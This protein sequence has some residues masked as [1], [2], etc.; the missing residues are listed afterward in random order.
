MSSF[1]T[2]TEIERTAFIVQIWNEIQ[3]K[4]GPEATADIA[5]RMLTMYNQ[6]GPEATAEY[7]RIMVTIYTHEQLQ[8]ER[9]F[10]R[11][12]TRCDM[13]NH[14]TPDDAKA[15]LAFAAAQF[16]SPETTA[17]LDRFEWNV[18]GPSERFDSAVTET[19]PYSV[20]PKLPRS[21]IPLS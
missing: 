2:R 12:I 15:T 9:K 8:A 21:S 3:P 5:S 19:A 11:E 7:A 6:L 10:S 14:V 4:I 20:A 1:S 13:R 17:L 18:I 16:D